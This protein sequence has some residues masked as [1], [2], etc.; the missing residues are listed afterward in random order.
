MIA[1]KHSVKPSVYLEFLN[2][3]AEPQQLTVELLAQNMIEEIGYEQRI[4]LSPSHSLYT[5]GG[6]AMR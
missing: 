2:D 4:Y 3:S 1:T 6:L 5:L